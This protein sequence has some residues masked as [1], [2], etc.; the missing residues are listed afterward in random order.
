MPRSA[1]LSVASGLSGEP[2][3][4]AAEIAWKNWKRGRQPKADNPKAAM[5]APK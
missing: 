4:S 5:L 1:A 2:I 3:R